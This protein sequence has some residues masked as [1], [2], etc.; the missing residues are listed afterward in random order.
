MD[1]ITQVNGQVQDG[2]VQETKKSEKKA[3]APAE[4]MVRIRLP[5]TREEKEPVPVW[6]NERSWLIQR[7]QEVEV[8][9]YVA[10]VLRN[11][12]LMLE[13]GI[14]YDEDHEAREAR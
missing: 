10:E 7:G 5:I 11:K 2:Q 13:Y 12:E 3:K 14:Q 4:K 9:E 6:V 1:N 8:P